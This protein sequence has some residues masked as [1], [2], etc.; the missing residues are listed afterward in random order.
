MFA[1]V[2]ATPEVGQDMYICVSLGPRS[3][4]RG[5]KA[6]SLTSSKESLAIFVSFIHAPPEYSNAQTT[7]FQSALLALLT[8]SNSLPKNWSSTLSDIG[9]AVSLGIGVLQRFSLAI[10]AIR[11]VSLERKL[12]ALCHVSSM[13]GSVFKSDRVRHSYER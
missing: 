5:T 1:G 13:E 7:L 3:T 11:K 10:P 9:V 12:G 2:S 8:T 6:L 4:H